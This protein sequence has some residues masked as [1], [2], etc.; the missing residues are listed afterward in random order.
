[1]RLEHK[2]AYL[3]L[4]PVSEKT[5][6]TATNISTNTELP[7]WQHLKSVLT[8]TDSTRSKTGST[9]TPPQVPPKPYTTSN[10]IDQT[11][12]TQQSQFQ[13]TLSTELDGGYKGIGE[14]PLLTSATSTTSTSKYESTT[15]EKK[16]SSFDFFKK[17]ESEGGTQPAPPGERYQKQ[18]VYTINKR[19]TPLTISRPSAPPAQ[20]A[21]LANTLEDDLKNLNLIPGSP[22]E[23]CFIPKFADATNAKPQLINDRIKILEASQ[24]SPKEP[25]IGGIRT[26]PL[27]PVSQTLKHESTMSKEVKVE[28]GQPII[29]QAATLPAS[30]QFTR[31][32]SPKPSAEG[33]AMSKL[34]TPNHLSGYESCTSEMEQRYKVEAETDAKE[35][36]REIRVQKVPTP[37]PDL[38]APYLVKEISKAINVPITPQREKTPLD[39][40]HLVPG[41]PPEICYAPKP[42]VRRQS[43]VEKME[44]TLEQNLQQGPKKVLP[45]SVPTLT[46][47]MAPQDARITIPYKPPPPVI[48]TKLSVGQPYESDYESD[49]WKYSGSE[50]DEASFRP[51]GNSVPDSLVSIP[52]V[53]AIHHTFK[54]SGYAAD[55]EEISSYRKMESTHQESRSFYESTSS[56]KSSHQVSH[57]PQAPM[58]SVLRT[59]PQQQQ[60]TPQAAPAPAPAASQTFYQQPQFEKLSPA[61]LYYTRKEE[62]G[63]EKQEYSD[64][65]EY[66]REEKVR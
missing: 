52:S 28:Y 29:R 17:I 48:P 16:S 65:N 50:S 7:D 20:S 21:M 51:V 43:L 53:P 31:S 45:M 42:E 25:P 15:S 59:P 5:P 2:Q 66:R 11:P 27:L 58:T 57:A 46:P 26:L 1:M 40:I 36:K 37:A 44:K 62:G 13:T 47:T 23:I 12:P 60:Y 63:H 18:E 39:D 24:Q 4:P 22:P 8:N 35:E 49:R 33:V 30:Q 41:S 6:I 34:W 56:S 19:T 64:K 3:D 14:A 61:P 9:Q 54:T 38:S 32:P 55:T 10:N